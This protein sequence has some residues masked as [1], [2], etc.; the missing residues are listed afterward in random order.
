MFLRVLFLL[1]LAANVGLAAWLSLAPVPPP[2]PAPPAADPGVPVLRLLS[3]VQPPDPEAAA[4]E[5]AAAPATPAEEALDQCVR[6]GPFMAQSDL[7]RAMDALTPRVKRIQFHEDRQR[8]PRGFL[9]YLAAP[10]NRDEALRV[11]RRL[12][13]KG[14][15]DYYVVTAGEQQNSISLGLFKERTNAEK[16]QVDLRELGFEAEIV[17]RADELPVYW[18]DYAIAPETSMSWRDALPDFPDLREEPVSCS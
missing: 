1:L 6:L 11:A 5:L 4:A 10:P 7:R 3:E 13:A 2:P 8:Q 16:R 15:R 17:E 14:V 18:L 12:S 9:V